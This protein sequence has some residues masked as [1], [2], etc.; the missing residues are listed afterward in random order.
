MIGHNVLDEQLKACTQLVGNG[1]AKAISGLAQMV[2]RDIRISAFNARRVPVNQAPDLVGGWETVTLGVYLGVTGCATGH[3]FMVYRPETA[4]A[5]ADLLM[6]NPA[7]T[8]K[9]LA[10]MEES[11]LGELGNIMASG[12]LNSI[13]DATGLSLQ[14]T[15]PAVM[16]DMA[17]AILDVAMASILEE[18]DQALVVE[19]N[20][21]T[22]DRQISG[23]L[24]VMPSPDLLRTLLQHI[25]NGGKHGG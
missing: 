22:A 8:T 5:L 9:S 18:S 19:T 24:L 14:P 12:F 6:G 23:A 2:G 3:M 15:P 25:T 20:F 4:M 11:A 16:M 17:G 10:E 21:S 13:S 1:S 7:G